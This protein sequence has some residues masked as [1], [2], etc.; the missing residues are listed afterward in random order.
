[1]KTS[2][3]W[4]AEWPNIAR[5]NRTNTNKHTKT[6]NLQIYNFLLEHYAIRSKSMQFSILQWVLSG[7]SSKA[8]HSQS[9][10][11]I[12]ATRSSNTLPSSAAVP[13]SNLSGVWLVPFSAP[14][15]ACSEG[16]SDRNLRVRG[17]VNPLVPSGPVGLRIT[18]I[19]RENNIG[20]VE[21][22]FFIT[23]SDLSNKFHSKASIGHKD[24]RNWTRMPGDCSPKF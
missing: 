3:V 8:F 22:N 21:K 9:W 17:W 13:F 19:L 7:C 23:W 10:S 2:W 16:A 14:P 5:L 18:S 11:H 15:W 20:G 12:L 4:I 1:M 24:N 6:V